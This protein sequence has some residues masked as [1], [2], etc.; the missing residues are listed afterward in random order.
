MRN[1]LYLIV[2][3]IIVVVFFGFQNQESQKFYRVSLRFAL[4]FRKPFSKVFLSR[5]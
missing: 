3:T 5:C 4:S 1:F 2:A